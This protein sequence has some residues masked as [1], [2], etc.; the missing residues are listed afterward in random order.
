MVEVAVSKPRP[1]RLLHSRFSTIVLLPGRSQYTDR[2]ARIQ[3]QD[4][5]KQALAQKTCK[6]FERAVNRP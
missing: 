2:L 1:D 4:E 5:G 3:E 6:A